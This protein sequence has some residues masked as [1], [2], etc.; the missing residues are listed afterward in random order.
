MIVTP[1]PQ[2][3]Y[4]GGKIVLRRQIESRTFFFTFLSIS[5]GPHHQNCTLAGR[6]KLGLRRYD[7]ASRAATLLANEREPE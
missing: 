7:V 2:H 1:K 4:Q 6:D 3:Q 5:E